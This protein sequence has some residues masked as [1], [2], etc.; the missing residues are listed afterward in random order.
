[1]EKGIKKSKFKHRSPANKTSKKEGREMKIKKL[2]VDKIRIMELLLTAIIVMSLPVVPVSA[3]PSTTPALTQQA[4]RSP[5]RSQYLKITNQFATI[6]AVLYSQPGKSSPVGLVRS[7]PFSQSNLAGWPCPE[8]AAR[9]IDILCFN[10]RFSNQELNTIWEQLALDVAAAVQ[11]MWDRGYAHVVLFGHSAGGPL[12]DYYQNSGNERRLPAGDA[13]VTIA[14]TIG[15]SASFLLRLDGSVLDETTASRHPALDMFNPANGF[16]PA[17][18]TG[19]YNAAFLASYH[20]AQCDRM[21]RLIDSVQGQL[22]DISAGE[23][24][25][26]DN[27]FIIIPG[28]RANPA[29]ADLSLAHSTTTP[30]ILLPSGKKEIVNSVRP[31]VDNSRRNPSAGGSAQQTLI[32]FLSYRAVHCTN[33]DPEAVTPEG[34]GVDFDSVNSTGPGNIKNVTV[35]IL[36]LQGTA[37]TEVHLTSAELNF[38]SATSTSDKTLKFIEGATHGFTPLR[39]EFGDTQAVAVETIIQWIGERFSVRQ[40]K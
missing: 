22:D 23:G 32:S 36:M 17:T 3:Q 29:N 1:M 16:N 14:S 24:R 25:F 13:L 10:N 15:T 27:N 26:T 8:I 37:D 12:M 19:S 5:V 31:V 39:P 20:T 34:S 6:D 4:Q 18:G 30:Y 33:Y 9:G 21:N 28:V 2:Q 35:P 40:A 38:N 11:E 7:H